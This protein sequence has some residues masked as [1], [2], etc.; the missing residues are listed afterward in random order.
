MCVYNYYRHFTPFGAN[1]ICK[2]VPFS[3]ILLCQPLTL[4]QVSF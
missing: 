1:H 2:A 4:K 3:K